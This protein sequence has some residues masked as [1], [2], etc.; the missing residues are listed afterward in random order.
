[1]KK[2]NIALLLVVIVI[3]LTGGRAIAQD[4]KEYKDGSVWV[5]GIIKT[6]TGMKDEYL[7]SLKT[8][9]VAIQEEAIKQGFLLSYKVIS[10]ASSSP[11]DWDLLL[12]QEYK[13]LATMEANKDKWEAIQKKIVGGEEAAKTLNQNRVSMREMYGNKLMRE[14]TFK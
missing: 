1:M 8:T 5:L 12:M 10:G 6:K 13:D 7:K 9:W 4:K 2:V 11:E 14:V 3:I